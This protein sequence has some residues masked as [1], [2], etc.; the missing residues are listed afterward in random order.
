MKISLYTKYKNTPT[1]SKIGVILIDEL[2][3]SSLFDSHN[4]LKLI[5][6]GFSVNSLIKLIYDLNM[7]LSIMCQ[8]SYVLVEKMMLS[9]SL[10]DMCFHK[11]FAFN[12]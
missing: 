3:N 4:Y 7:L 8:W 12:S 6:N 11:N 1:D 2:N 10:R 9:E 5:E